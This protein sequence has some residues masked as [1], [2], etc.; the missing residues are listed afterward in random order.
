MSNE[1]S[2]RAFAPDTFNFFSAGVLPDPGHGGVQIRP[3][4]W[5]QRVGSVA[6]EKWDGTAWKPA[7]WA[8]LGTDSKGAPL[9]APADGTFSNHTF[10]FGAGTGTVDPAAGT[11]HLT[12]DG[13]VTVLF[14]SG[15]SFFVV[16]D[17]ALDVAGGR[18]ELTGTLS[19]YASSQDNPDAWA[20]VAPQR[21]TLATLP[22]VDLGSESGFVAIPAY[23]GVRVSGVPQVTTGASSGSFPQSFVDYQGQLGSAPFWFSSGASTDAF[24]VA[25]PVTVGLD[26]AAPVVAPADDDKPDK[27]D[28]V[29]N[30][31][32]PPPHSDG[33]TAAAPV[34]VPPAAVAAPPLPADAALALLARPATTVRLVSATTS[35]VGAGAAA[36]PWWTGGAL[37]LLA[38]ALLLLDPTPKKRVNP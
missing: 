27:P 21:V 6:V 2:N 34:A 18:G 11:A 23:A 26:E 9:G 22:Q 25:L 16:S 10:V 13:D 7:T 15:M 38:A 1:A 35:P 24:K 32:A 20:P 17:P 8:G 19:G 31:A 12:W 5:H 37:L 4:Q 33:S 30:S 29:R 3:D 28:E 14:Y 36:W